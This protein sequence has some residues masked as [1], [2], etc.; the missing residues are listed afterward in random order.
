M[1]DILAS[2]GQRG[3]RLDADLV[4]AQNAMGRGQQRNNV[5]EDHF[6]EYRAAPGS[7][8]ARD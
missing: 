7:D 4:F 1:A 8:V 6:I 5:D 3:K 2:Y